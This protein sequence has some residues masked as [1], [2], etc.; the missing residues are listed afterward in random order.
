MNYIS[1]Y[2]L[3]SMLVDNYYYKYYNICILIQVVV[4]IAKLFL[5][6]LL[7]SL[8]NYSIVFSLMKFLNLQY[9]ISNNFHY[10]Q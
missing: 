2:L 5:I 4:N 7:I 3:T 8:F 1:K 10:N 9:F 6:D